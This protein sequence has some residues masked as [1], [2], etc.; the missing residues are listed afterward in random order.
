MHPATVRA[1]EEAPLGVVG[2]ISFAAAAAAVAGF[3]TPAVASG[4]FCASLP[5]A[6]GDGFAALV[7]E[8]PARQQPV[9]T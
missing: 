6:V 8:D 2:P 7:A 4:T 9:A 1:V 5:E 3:V